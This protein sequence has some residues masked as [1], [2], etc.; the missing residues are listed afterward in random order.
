MKVLYDK[1]LFEYFRICCALLAIVEIENI[2]HNGSVIYYLFLCLLIIGCGFMVARCIA[3]WMGRC[4]VQQSS[5]Y[6]NFI[7]SIL[8]LPYTLLLIT[9]VSPIENKIFEYVIIGVLAVFAC[10]SCK[11][12]D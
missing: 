4:D 10:F 7:S 6:S 2:W 11:D 8:A 5:K 1:V 3:L 12:K 9:I